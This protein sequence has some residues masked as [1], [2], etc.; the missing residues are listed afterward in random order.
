MKNTLKAIS[1]AITALS[2][3]PKYTIINTQAYL[4]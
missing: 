1:K 3:I 4:F 2:E